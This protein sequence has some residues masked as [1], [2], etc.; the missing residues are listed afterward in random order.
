MAWVK[1][2]ET[3]AIITAGAGSQTVTLPGTPAIGDLVLVAVAGDIS[4]QNSVPS[5]YT[6][7]ENTTGANPGA[8]FGYKVLTSADT[9]VA[10]LRDTTILKACVVQIWRGGNTAAAIL[11]AAWATPVAGTSTQPDPPAV[12]T[13]STDALVVTVAFLDDDDTTVSS[14]PTS[15]TNLISGNTGQASTTVGATVALASRVIA[16]ASTENPAVWTFGSSDAWTVSTIAFKIFVAVVD[17]NATPANETLHISARGGLKIIGRIRSIDT[18]TPP[19]LTGGGPADL[20]PPLLTET[21]HI[22]EARTVTL[23][24]LEARPAETL[25]ISESVTASMGLSATPAETFHLS[26]SAT[27][28]TSPLEARP[29]ET[30]HI[31]EEVDPELIAVGTLFASPDE[32]LH[33]TDVGGGVIQVIGQIRSRDYFLDADLI[34]EVVDLERAVPGETLHLSDVATVVLTPLVVV[35]VDTLHITDLATVRIDL[36]VTASETL[37][38]SESSTVTLTPLIATL[39]ETLHLSDTVTATIGLLATPSET[40]HLSEAATVTLTPLV[41]TAAETLH[42]IESATVT[43]TPLVVVGLETLH[44]SEPVTAS[45]GLTVVQAD[46]LHLSESATVRLTPLIVTT[47][48]TLHISELAEPIL[49]TVGPGLTATPADETLHVADAVDSWAGLEDLETLHITDTVYREL[50]GAGMGT[51]T[52]PNASE[53]LHV[54]DAVDSWAGLDD[55]E[56]LH[57]NDDDLTVVRTGLGALWQSLSETLHIVGGG[58]IQVIGQIRSRDY[59]PTV[60]RTDPNQLTQFLPTETLH[61]A[62]ALDSWA[63]IGSPETL[64]ISDSITATIGISRDVPPETL[65]I[66]ESITARIGLAVGVTETLHISETV[67][68]NLTPLQA[69]SVK[70]CTSR[71]RSPH[72]PAS[73]R[74]CRKHCM[75]SRKRGSASRIP[76]SSTSATTT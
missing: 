15:Y 38:L 33:I 64:H 43:L 37:H 2:S 52:V 34:T 30:L 4:C 28:V 17:L 72:A 76:S 68:R 75:S 24:P 41:V 61:V 35:T 66:S 21:L 74:P 13:T 57:L 39:A 53:T 50:V 65:H 29:A 3:S 59:Q 5:D 19:T 26:E 12:T 58:V 60:I 62:D 25:H 7:P 36:A 31:T 32:T 16:S 67:T 14:A 9:T 48:E 55:L 6:R 40:L 20:A 10:I 63:Q 46:T 54:A 8:C 49:V 44:I 51:L 23:T 70:R 56:T 18:L 69:S 11:D 27:V 1:H 71:R 47:G 42:I 22:S 45:M 73:R